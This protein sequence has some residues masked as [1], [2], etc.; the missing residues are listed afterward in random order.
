MIRFAFPLYLFGFLLIAVPLILHLLKRKPELT[1]RF[2]SLFFLRKSPAAKE[3]HNTLMKYLVLLFRCLAFFC[4]AAGFAYPVFSK[5]VLNPERTTVVLVD[6]SFSMPEDDG[7]TMEPL[8]D[9]VSANHPMLIGAVTSRTRWSGGDFSPDPGTLSGWYE[10]NRE[11]A[12]TSSFR[13]AILAADSRLGAITAREKRIVILTDGQRV[14]WNRVDLSRKLRN[15]SAFEVRIVPRP[16]GGNLAVTKVEQLEPYTRES[17]TV[18][19]AATVRNCNP[20]PQTVL[21]SVLLDG[22]AVDR[23]ELTVPANGSAKAEFPLAPG[24]PFAPHD[25]EVRLFPVSAEKNVNMILKDDNRYFALNPVRSPRI[26]LSGS[27]SEFIPEVLA[28][29]S[30]TPDSGKDAES[31]ELLIFDAV[32]ADG[33]DRSA[34]LAERQMKNGG[35]TVIL[36]N[37]S[38]GCAA[39]LERFGVRVRR[40][41]LPGV[42]RLTM[43]QF[44]HP[45]LRDYLNVNSGS[46]FDILFFEVPHL[47]VPS[48]AVVLASFDGQIPAILEKKIGTGKL[49]VFAARPGRTRTNWQTFANFLPFWRELALYSAKPE[50]IAHSLTADGSAVTM[51][52]GRSL[53]LDTPGNYRH[54]DRV[55]SVNVP[56]QESDPAKAELSPIVSQLLDPQV[57]TRLEETFV[58]RAELLKAAASKS[59]YWR[60]LLLA[61]LVFF[62]LEFTLANRTVR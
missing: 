17:R 57:K 12:E 44:D 34:A 10:T 26:Y 14:P 59:S 13:S 5:S 36:W 29:K 7:N 41:T 32:P 18:T 24:A 31:A 2:P 15:A 49:F 54:G 62:L 53:T 42:R 4:L 39:M 19:V 9:E 11:T 37:R 55:Y 20:K 46:W 43:L 27:H 30:L 33:A 48:D 3:K 50:R 47:S 40:K 35:T 38:P 52:D 45:V 23:T 60:W 16:D 51:P 21:L 25:G 1:Q 28:V 61:A 22:K 56:A 8:L 6:A 58:S